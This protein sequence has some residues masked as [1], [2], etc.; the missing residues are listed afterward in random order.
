[1]HHH[2]LEA[3]TGQ[4]SPARVCPKVSPALFAQSDFAVAIATVNWFITAGFEGYLGLFAALGTYCGKHLAP[5]PVVATSV[6]L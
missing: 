3:Y 1:M 2:I 5:G 6:T 4:V